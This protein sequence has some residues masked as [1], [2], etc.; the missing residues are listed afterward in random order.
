[1][2]RVGDRVADEDGYTGTVTE[3]LS[4]RHL[5]GRHEE[6]IRVRLDPISRP[7][8]SIG[9]AAFVFPI[10]TEETYRPDQLRRLK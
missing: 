1:M 5:D 2:F 4:V 10:T 8:S 3:I 9:N 6:E 7:P